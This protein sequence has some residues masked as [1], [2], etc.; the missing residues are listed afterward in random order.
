MATPC[1]CF[2]P[3]FRR[4]VLLARVN[5]L[6]NRLYS[7]DIS[8]KPHDPVVRNLGRAIIDDF[9]AIRSRYRAPKNPIVLAHGL[10]GFDEL[11]LA[12]ALLP[13]IH[14]WRGITDAL[15]KNG[16]EVITTSVPA[17]SSIEKRAAKLGR[18]IEKKAGGKSVN[19]IAHS[20]TMS[21]SELDV[22]S[23]P[24]LPV[25]PVFTSSPATSLPRIYRALKAL[26][27]ETGAF[28][29][30]TRRF[31]KEDFNP[32]TPNREGVRYLSYG[33][34]IDPPIWSAFRQSHWIVHKEEGVND[35][36]VSVESSKWGDYQGTLVNV[37]HLDLINWT[38]R[39]RWLVW[40]LTGNKRKRVQPRAT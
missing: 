23:R 7:K 24:P 13:G 1:C 31:M 40:E 6:Q 21:L 2:P 20:M 33:A 22:S 34:S 11:H 39:L 30:L 37:S 12:G 4:N 36:L 17:S 5:V 10:L 9:A 32:K 19:I 14:Y 18:D 28:S 38:N 35:G 26:R 16:I 3:I 29:Q 27:I 8:G 15:K 25:G